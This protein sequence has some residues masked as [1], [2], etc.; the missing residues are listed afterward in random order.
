MGLYDR[1]EKEP[2]DPRERFW[3]WFMKNRELVG[4]LLD[5]WGWEMKAYEELT[6]EIKQVHEA[7]IPE[8]TRDSDGTN[9]L[10]ISADGSR[11]AVGPVIELSDAAPPIPG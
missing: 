3:A 4:S 7:L 8:L 10:V 9:V 11:E 1:S 6:K 2:T 5:H